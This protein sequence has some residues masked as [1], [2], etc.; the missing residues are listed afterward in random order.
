MKCPF[1]IADNNNCFCG[2]VSWLLETEQRTETRNTRVLD[3]KLEIFMPKLWPIDRKTSSN[4]FF[5]QCKQSMRY[6]GKGAL[7]VRMDFMQTFQTTTKCNNINH[8]WSYFYKS[9][10]V[11]KYHR[12]LWA[13]IFDTD[14]NRCLDKYLHESGVFGLFW[15]FMPLQM[16]VSKI[17]AH[18]RLWYFKT[19]KIL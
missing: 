12:C 11:L 14:I 1:F 13:N 15:I 6:K 7:C 5:V 10:V 2:N 9:L 18:G 4:P 3:M 8:V 19:T 16:S 17:L